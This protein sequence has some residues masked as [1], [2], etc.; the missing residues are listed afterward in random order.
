MQTMIVSAVDSY[1]QQQHCKSFNTER[2]PV[3]WP[4]NNKS[5][6]KLFHNDRI[7]PRQL[8]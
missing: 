5:A 2:Q 3:K 8:W 6:G 4:L 1:R 7:A